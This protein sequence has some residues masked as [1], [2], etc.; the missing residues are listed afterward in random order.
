MGKRKNDVRPLNKEK[1]SK[2]LEKP[3]NLMEIGNSNKTLKSYCGKGLQVIKS[4]YR[5][6]FIF[7]D[8]RKISASID[9]DEA[10]K[11][12][13]SKENRWDYGIEYDQNLIFAEVHPAQTSEIDCMIKK[14]QSIKGW[15]ND[16]CKEL[17]K[18]PKFEKGERQ[19]YWV[20]SGGNGILPNSR[21]AKRLAVVH[22]CPVGSI[23]DYAKIIKVQS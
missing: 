19:F 2:K 7:P 13:F 12:T 5:S 23:F 1:V 6:K 9:F 22:I 16:N 18:L 21:Q 10:L 3:Q 15:I 8:T 4:G 17:L 14:V 11:E 20:A